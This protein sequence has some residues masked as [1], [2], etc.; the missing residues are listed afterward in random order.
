MCV[1]VSRI[2]S[3]ATVFLYNKRELQ[4]KSCYVLILLWLILSGMIAF[5]PFV[6]KTEG[7]NYTMGYLGAI[8]GILGMICSYM[9]ARFV[10][11]DINLLKNADRIR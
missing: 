9:A 3:F 2:L 11:K 5:C 4:V 7:L 8:A 10:K 6:V 1:T